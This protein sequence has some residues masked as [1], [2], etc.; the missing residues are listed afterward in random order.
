[1]KLSDL[2]FSESDIEFTIDLFAYYGEGKANAKNV[3][4]DLCEYFELADNH[5]NHK[6]LSNKIRTFNPN[7]KDCAEHYRNRYLMK[8]NHNLTH[9]HEPNGIFTRQLHALLI[10]AFKVLSEKMTPALALKIVEAEIRFAIENKNLHVQESIARR[11]LAADTGDSS[12]L[13]GETEPDS[14]KL[15]PVSENPPRKP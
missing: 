3:I 15:Q 13:D 8:R 9:R 12:F 7:R 4:H 11:C 5:S 14:P 1:M 6:S 10:V 2:T